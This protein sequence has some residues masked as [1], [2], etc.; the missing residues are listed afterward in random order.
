MRSLGGLRA[1]RGEGVGTACVWIGVFMCASLCECVWGSRGALAGEQTLSRLHKPHRQHPSCPDWVLQGEGRVSRQLGHPAPIAPARAPGLGTSVAG[2]P[3]TLARRGPP[4][5]WLQTP[6]STNPPH[7]N[8]SCLPNHLH[9]SYPNVRLGAW[10]GLQVH[11]QT[12]YWADSLTVCSI[13][14][15]IQ[16]NTGGG[17]CWKKVGGCR[18]VLLDSVGHC[19]TAIAIH[20]ARGDK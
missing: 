3:P 4:K 8:V 18:R 13:R 2:V 19:S 5:V 15:P 6:I 7:P 16:H 9:P 17:C 14:L 10:E 12:S 20:S 11:G 1:D